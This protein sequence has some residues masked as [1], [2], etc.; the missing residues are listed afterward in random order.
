HL[1]QEYVAKL[2]FN[3]GSQ[4]L[5]PFC[6]TGTT[7]VE[8]KK[9]GIPSVGIEANPMAQFAARVKVDWCIDPDELQTHAHAVARRA[10]E[11]LAS[12]GIADEALNG[13][14]YD[15]G[16]EL[17]VIAPQSMK[18]LLANSI[19]PLALHKALVLL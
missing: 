8:C 9:L 16:A 6:G 14:T 7:P 2:G 11:H 13:Q 10:A 1:V 4:I 17:R 3:E 19:R 5:D 18:L 12:E 15:A